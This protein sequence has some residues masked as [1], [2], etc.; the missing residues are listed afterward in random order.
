SPIWE[1]IQKGNGL[2]QVSID[3]NGQIR[4]L[5]PKI[6]EEILEAIKSIFGGNDESKKIQKYLLKQQFE[7]FF[8]SNSEGLH[9]G[10]DR[11]ESLMG[12]LETH[13]ACVSTEDANQKFLRSLPSS[14]SQV[15]LIMR[16]KPGVDT[17]N[18]D[19]L[20]NNLRV[21]ESNL[22]GSIG[23]SS[24]TH[25]VT[26]VS[27]DN[28]SSTNEVNTA[29]G[30]STS[31][32]HN[33]QK[34]GFT[35]YT[36]DLMCSFFANQSSGPQLDHEDL[37]QVDEFDLEEMDLKCRRRDAGNT[38][39]KERDN[40]KRPVKQDKQKAMVTID[41]EGV[42]WT[43]HAEDEIEDYALMAFNS[44]NLGSDTEMSAK[45]KF[46]LGCGS[47]I[48]D[49]V[50]SYENK[51]FESVFDSSSSDVEDS[52][53]NDRLEKVEGMHAIP[54]PMTGNYMPPKSNFG[55]DE[56]KFTYGPKQSTTSE[57]DAKTSDLDSCE[58]SS[59]EET[60]ETVPKPVESKPNKRDWNG[61]K[62]KKLGLGY[63]FTK[64]AC[65]VCGSFSHL[66]RDCD[67]HKKRM[68][69][70]VELNKQKGQSTDPKENRPVW[71]NV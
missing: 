27:S 59:S 71:N 11:F 55:I 62:S 47:Q 57:S 51:V 45:D 1:V 44:S 40:G 61:L 29:F 69:K 3:T 22:K 10:Y 56:S 49:G 15:S 60:L 14:W 67:F 23:S 41:G 35:S 17:L 16:T 33:S 9:K 6:A 31:F 30:V 2:I 18:F 64:K 20:Y 7:S 53:V 58:S 48:H 8:V 43:G 70:Q 5:P 52:P 68:A 39:Y 21:F 34:E 38:G 36:N 66:I 13:G 54:P 28:T 42:D 63:G 26:F 46:W 37:K 32:S 65:F 19:D 4:V 24:S 50:L 12:Q 25:N